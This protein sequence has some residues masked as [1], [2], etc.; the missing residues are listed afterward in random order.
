M[1]KLINLIGAP[2]SGKS[3]TAMG[4][5]Y[6]LKRQGISAEYVDE[7]AK[8]FSLEQR[9]MALSCQPFVFGNQLMKI[10]RVWG[11]YDY[12]IT[13]CPLI[14]NVFYGNYLHAGKYPEHFY[15]AVINVARDYGG[16]YFFLQHDYSTYETTGRNQTITEALDIQGNMESLLYDLGIRYSIWN[17]DLNTAQHIVNKVLQNDNKDYAY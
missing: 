16:Q 15:N 10:E 2:C 11:K 17:L 4:V 3:A 13:D 14:L 12:I 9:Q 5:T 1:S 6:L 7:T 8:E